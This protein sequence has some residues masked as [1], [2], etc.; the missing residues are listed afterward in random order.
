MSKIIQKNEQLTQQL[1]VAKTRHEHFK[2]V[3]LQ[4]YEKKLA[5]KDGEVEIL[6]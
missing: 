3:S 1:R 2:Q 4:D 6:K 5:E